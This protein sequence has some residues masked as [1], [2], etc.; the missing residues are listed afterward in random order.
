MRRLRFAPLC[1]LAAFLGVAVCQPAAAAPMYVQSGDF[2]Y[3]IGNTPTAISWTQT[4]T[5][6]DVEITL[7]LYSQCDFSPVVCAGLPATGTAYLT[8]SI[9]AS[10]TQVANEIAFASFS[11]SVY[12][13]HTFT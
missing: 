2:H 1:L 3:V 4:D 9:G 12:G 10:T 5:W 7:G 11:D 6:S 13:F 8:D